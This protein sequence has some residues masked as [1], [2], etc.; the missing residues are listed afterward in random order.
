MSP[1]APSGRRPRTVRAAVADS[2]AVDAFTVEALD[3]L[4]GAGLRPLLL[5]G[6]A[7]AALLYEPDEER[8]WDDADI[9]VAPDE[10]GQALAVLAG[11]G[12]ETKDAGE[13]ERD[14]V[15]YET[16]L[17]RDA[18][19]PSASG[20]VRE[21]VDLHRSFAG[22]QAEPG[23]FWASIDAE[24]ASIELFGRQVDVPSV[25]ARLAMVALHAACHGRPVAQ[26]VRDLRRAVARFEV[27]PETLAAAA[28][29]ARRWRALDYFVA[30]IRLDPEGERLLAGLGIEHEP[31]RAAKMHAAGMG[32]A[33]FAIEHFARTPT[34]SGRIRLVAAKLA[35]RPGEMRRRSRLARRGPLGLGAAYLCRPFWLLAQLAMAVPAYVRA[36][37]RRAS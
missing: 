5:K 28:E 23:D 1:T 6:P 22:V 32:S 29:L 11:I 8:F 37:R 2:L 14:R 7:V 13:L 34:A 30:G 17:V 25:P 33:E 4:E 19:H 36:G 9:L 18:V 10:H 24:R 12:F 3:A 21:M 27:S 16:H 31:S 35:P 26:P 20:R 15:P